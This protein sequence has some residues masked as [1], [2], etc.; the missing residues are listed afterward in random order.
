MVCLV[1]TMHLSCTDTNTV[2][3][4][5]GMRFDIT[6][7][8]LEFHRVHPKRFL[9]LWYVWHKLCTYIASRLALFQT[10]Q[11]ELPLEPCHQ[12]VPLGAFKM[13]PEPVVCLAQTMHLSCTDTNT[14]YKWTGTRFDMTHVT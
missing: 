12:G 2:Y 3:K 8:T 5:I 10:D 13:I 9:S 14:V 7:V 4:W 1:Q 6:H 11:N